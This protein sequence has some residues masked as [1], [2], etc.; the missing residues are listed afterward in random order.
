[1]LVI[2]INTLANFLYLCRIDCNAIECIFLKFDNYEIEFL[3]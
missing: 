1:M 3:L 2:S